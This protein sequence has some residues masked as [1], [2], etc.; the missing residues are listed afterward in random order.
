ME[1]QEAHCCAGCAAGDHTPHACRRG[2]MAPLAPPAACVDASTAYEQPLLERVLR[3]RG[4]AVPASAAAASLAASGGAPLLQLRSARDV[5]WGPVLSGRCAASALA[6]RTALTR[7]AELARALARDAA[8]R[9][10]TPATGHVEPE[11]N[12]PETY[13]IDEDDDTSESDGD[14]DFADGDNSQGSRLDTIGRAWAAARGRGGVWVLKPS[15]ANRGHAISFLRADEGVRAQAPP[16]HGERHLRSLIARGGGLGTPWVLQRRVERPLLY[17]RRKTHLRIHFVLC[18]DARLLVHRNAALVLP[19]AREYDASALADKLVHVTN[20]C[21]Q[22]N[23]AKQEAQAPGEGV[24][25]KNYALHD[26]LQYVLE[27]GDA[28]ARACVECAGGAQ[29]ACESILRSC[30]ASLASAVR[31][32]PKYGLLFAPGTFELFG[33]D[34]IV[35]D[36]LRPW[37]LEINADP[38]MSLFEEERKEMC[39]EMWA[40]VVDIAVPEALRALDLD[41]EVAAGVAHLTTDAEMCD[42]TDDVWIEAW[43]REAT[44]TASAARKRARALLQCAA[45]L[46]ATSRENVRMG[47]G[48]TDGADFGSSNRWRVSWSESERGSRI[49]ANAICTRPGWSIDARGQ[50]GGAAHVQWVSHSVRE[51]AR[52]TRA[53]RVSM[54]ASS[55]GATSARFPCICV[56]LTAASI[57]PSLVGGRLGSRHRWAGDCGAFLRSLCSNRRT[58]ACPVGSQLGAVGFWRERNADPASAAFAHGHA[59]CCRTRRMVY[60]CHQVSGFPRHFFVR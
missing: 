49:A 38:S 1:G 45:A 29:L 26:F 21:V 11:A 44:S 25:A 39:E 8:A 41:A 18:G 13:V 22:K 54:C 36:T 30:G 53:C 55:C 12:S 60:F 3:A 14:G 35:D 37:L 32:S 20:H 40:N 19:A 51:R 52:L 59:R 6:V 15:E 42:T 57:W 5:D 43:H 4:W 33:A 56:E 2:A 7:K 16:N 47:G 24:R 10:R 28:N 9:R 34:F 17:R 27:E 48:R 23:A 58:C 50:R 31:G 46:L